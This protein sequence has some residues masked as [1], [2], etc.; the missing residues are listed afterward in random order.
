[1]MVDS[2]EPCPL[3]GGLRGLLLK[4]N[5][6]LAWNL[7]PFDVNVPRARQCMLCYQRPWIR[8]I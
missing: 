2:H 5:T 8:G 3:S 4:R 6:K 1:M 7:D